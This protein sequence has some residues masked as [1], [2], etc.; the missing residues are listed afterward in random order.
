MFLEPHWTSFPYSCFVINSHLT[1]MCSSIKT[2]WWIHNSQ[3][4]THCYKLVV[5]FL[6]NVRWIQL[7]MHFYLLNKNGLRKPK[8]FHIMFKWYH[9]NQASIQLKPR[10]STTRLRSG[11]KT[12]LRWGRRDRVGHV[13][14][15][16]ATHHN[17]NQLHPKDT[18]YVIKAA[19]YKF[20]DH[21]LSIMRERGLYLKIH[22]NQLFHYTQQENYLHLKKL[23]RN[24]TRLTAN[25]SAWIVL[26]YLPAWLL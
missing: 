23:N 5:N 1:C 19:L 2:C 15:S 4:A 17:S 11:P 6:M 10:L 12:G 21:T 14:I 3:V 9:L 26:R 16:S 8:M 22:I 7:Q 20:W 24:L 13:Q 18:G 25:N